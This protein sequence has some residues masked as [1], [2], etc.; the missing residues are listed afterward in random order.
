MGIHLFFWP[1]ETHSPTITAAHIYGHFII[2]TKERPLKCKKLELKFI[3]LQV[4]NHLTLVLNFSIFFA[5]FLIDRFVFY[6]DLV[7]SWAGPACLR[8][9]LGLKIR[10][11]NKWV[12]F[13]LSGIKPEVRLGPNIF[14]L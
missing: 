10:P 1:L 13:E 14:D 9:G 5:L 4:F 11:T 7:C 2:I 3:F 12:G 8:S 6:C